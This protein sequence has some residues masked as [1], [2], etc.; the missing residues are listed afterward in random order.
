L[1]NILPVVVAFKSIPWSYYRLHRA[2]QAFCI[3][4]IFIVGV[5]AFEAINEH[6]LKFHY[7]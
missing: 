6:G 4:V 2:Y 3:I 1:H 7:F 5:I